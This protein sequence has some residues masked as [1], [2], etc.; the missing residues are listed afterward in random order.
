LVYDNNYTEYECETESYCPNGV[1]Y[2]N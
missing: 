1:V 2:D